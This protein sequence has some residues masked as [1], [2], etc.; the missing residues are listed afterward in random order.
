MKLRINSI[1][2]SIDGEANGWKGAGEFSTFIRFQG[3]NLDCSYCD[4]RYAQ[5]ASEGGVVMSLNEIIEKV[6]MPKVT[7][8]GGEPFLQPAVFELINRL[9][10][11]GKNISVETNGSIK[12]TKSAL[13]L[14][15]TRYIADCKLPSSGIQQTTDDRISQMYWWRCSDVIKFVVVDELD[16]QEFRR[17]MDHYFLDLAVSCVHGCERFPSFVVSP[18]IPDLCGTD[19]DLSTVFQQYG[20]PLVDRLLADMTRNPGLS[21][22]QFSLQVH[23]VLW[24]GATVER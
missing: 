22:V 5:H 10:G 14:P 4:T 11:L 8:T 1:F 23:K 3:C 12:P 18:G 6:R 9:A 13:L 16:Y 19:I 2:E 24:P 7:I 21:K 15:K 20:A 17:I